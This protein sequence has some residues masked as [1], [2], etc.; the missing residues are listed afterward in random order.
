MAMLD[1]GAFYGHYHGHPLEQ[2]RVL[3]T[4]LRARDPLRPIVWLVG[5]S[6]LD[7]KAWVADAAALR[8]CRG[9]ERVLRPPRCA[10]DVAAWLNELLQHAGQPPQA[11]VAVNAAVEESTLGGRRG[12]RRLLPHDELVREHLRPHDV[13]VAS[14]GG[15]DIALAPSLATIASMASLAHVASDAS[16]DAGTACGLA[17]LVGMFRDD[18]RRYLKA[19]CA[20]AL[21]RMVIACMVYAPHEAPEPSWA[22]PALAALRY[23]AAPARLQRVIRRVY[24]AGTCGVRV[25]GVGAVVPCPL[26]DVLDPSPASRD[27]VARVEPSAIGGRKLAAAFLRIILGAAGAGAAEAA[28]AEE[29]AAPPLDAQ[30]GGG[31]GGCA[32]GDE[33]AAPGGAA[34]A[35]SAPADADVGAPSGPAHPAGAATR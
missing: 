32:E 25:A 10:P 16:I 34:A 19:L 17:H 27:Y 1:A 2:L 28:G 13:I 24:A 4:E 29:S 14:L 6:T 21:P 15:N 23:N 12:G 33:A 9:Y 5:D 30:G 35:R 22:G 7:N 26:F 8:A 20:R 3:V 11:L 31:G 18:T